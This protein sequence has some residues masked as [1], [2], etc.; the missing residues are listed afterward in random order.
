MPSGKIITNDQIKGLKEHKYASEGQ[1]FLDVVFQPFWNKVVSMLPLWLA[2]NMIT[3][4][5]MLVNISITLVFVFY[6][7]PKIVVAEEEQAP[8]WLFFLV[9]FGVFFYQTLD[10][11]DGKQARRTGTASVLGEL[12]DH[13]CDSVTTIFVLLAV[14]IS[15]QP[16]SELGQMLLPLLGLVAF[17]VAHWRTYVTGKLHF[18]KVD[19]TEAQ[20]LIILVHVFRG[21]FGTSFWA[22]DIF[23]STAFPFKLTLHN[24]LIISSSG[25]A[26][27][28]IYDN[29]KHISKGGVGAEGTSVADTSFLAPLF[30]LVAGMFSAYHIGEY[31]VFEQAPILYLFSIGFLFA[32][33]SNKLIVAHM[34][35]SRLEQVDS[36]FLV[37]LLFTVNYRMGL[38][39]GNVLLLQVACALYLIN[40]VA[41]CV[42]VC[43]EL[44]G[45]LGIPILTIKPKSVDQTNQASH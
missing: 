39:F 27:N 29:F 33:L 13:G 20:W 6:Y 10:A 38:G 36:V 32:K 45:I 37:P 44:S 4:I 12:F 3:L 34:S 35:K 23:E 25:S 16:A 43:F 42:Q 41:Y 14:T 11:I 24:L 22:Y 5:G 1:P 26:L 7:Y 31:G 18:N 21:V 17:Y 9:A 19:V 28:S 30:P 15:A 2:A 8:T 40:L